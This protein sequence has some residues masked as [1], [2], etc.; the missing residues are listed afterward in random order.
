MTKAEKIRRIQ[1]ILEVKDSQEN[2]YADL[3][4]VMGDLKTNYGDYM[5]TEPIDCEAELKRVPKADYELCTALLSMILK[6][7]HFSDGA[8]DWRF[9]YRQVLTVLVRMRDILCTGV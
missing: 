9:T 7:E 6:E 3:L 1:R 4:E 8:S 5:I 2:V